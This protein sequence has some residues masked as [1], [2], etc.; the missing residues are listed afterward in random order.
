MSRTPL[1]R[2]LT[3]LPAQWEPPSRNIYTSMSSYFLKKTIIK[4]FCGDRPLTSRPSCSSRRRSPIPPW[5]CGRG[6]SSSRPRGEPP[7]PTCVQR[8]KKAIEWFFLTSCNNCVNLFNFQFVECTL[9]LRTSRRPYYSTELSCLL[10]PQ[11]ERNFQFCANTANSKIGG[12][13]AE[14]EQERDPLTDL[15]RLQQF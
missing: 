6:R 5:A 7:S 1:S 14:D 3:F 11:N 4:S 9:D 15:R 2:E 10:P 12:V 13:C 8:E